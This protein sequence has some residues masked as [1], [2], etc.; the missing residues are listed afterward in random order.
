MASRSEP[1][2]TDEPNAE[3]VSPHPAGRPRRGGPPRV[4][5][6]C[7]L[8]ALLSLAV[9]GCS[10]SI[11]GLSSRPPLTVEDWGATKVLRVCLLRDPA[12]SPLQAES[13]V[14]AWQQEIARFGIEVVVPW[15]RQ[16]QRPGFTWRPIAEALVRIPLEPGCDRLVALVGR[17]AGDAAYGLAATALAVFVPLPEFIGWVDNVT[18]THGFVVAQRT[19]SLAQAV[20]DPPAAMIH[21]GYH[22]LGCDHDTWRACYA[23]IAQMKREATTEG[24]FAARGLNGWIARS[25]EDVNAALAVARWE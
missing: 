11:G 21:E 22:L 18:M 14:Q 2:T 25:R 3:T 23:I 12:V 6:V 10:S 1:T 19:S 4:A 5:L 9:T 16:W 20:V 7:A 13:L 17:H 15:Q 8:A 24:F